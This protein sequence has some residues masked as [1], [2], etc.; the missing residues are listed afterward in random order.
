MSKPYDSCALS[1][2]HYIDDGIILLDHENRIQLWNRFMEKHSGIESQTIIGKNIFEAFSYLP[3]GWLELK[4]K[5]VRLLQSYSFISWTQRPYLFR[6]TPETPIL[7]DNLEYMYQDSIF[8]PVSDPN[9]ETPAV[10]IVIRDMTEVVS[11]TRQLEEMKDMTK[12]LVAIANYDSLTSIFNRG[13]I[14]KQLQQEFNRAARYDSG[15]SIILFDIDNFKKVNDYYGHLA[16]DEVLKELA[17]TVGNELRDSDIFGRFGGEEFVIILPNANE[18]ETT[19]VSEK[20]RKKIESTQTR[21]HEQTLSITVSQG[22]VQYSP[23]I[24]DYLQMLH[25]ADLALY[26]SKK[27]G[28]NKTSQYKNCICSIIES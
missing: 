22:F 25:E 27:N 15:F 11:S 3:K 13:Y 8:F 23:G 18:Q 21:Y 24:K 10:C 9:Y 17:R 19:I 7:G 12:T 5:S 4:L 20:L 6:F 14:E 16:G 28:R 1:I 26:H 2:L